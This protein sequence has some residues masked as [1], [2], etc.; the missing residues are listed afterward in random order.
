M[1]HP[2]RPEPLFALLTLLSLAA[3]A[4]GQTAVP[5]LPSAA[6]PGRE[7]PRPL[8]PT[9]GLGAAPVA[10]PAAP[11]TSAPAGA[12]ALR[13][14]LARVQVDGATHFGADALKPLYADL[15]GREITVAQAFGVAQAL[16]LRY[17]NAGFVTTRVLVP[18]QTIED[19]SFRI[20][21]V[22]GFL[23]DIVFDADIGPARAAVE[24]LV[25]PLKGVKPVNLADIERRLLL[26]ND[27]GG[28]SVRATLEPAP[29]ALGG[30][31]LRVAAQRRASEGSVSAD[32]RTSPYLGW[33][34]VGASLS[35]NALGER[36]DRIGL[37][38]RSSLATG[39]SAMA[40]VAYDA[41]LS[42]DGLGLNLSASLATS[43]PQRELQGLD[44]KS[45]VQSG[46]ATLSWPLVRS[47]TMN[48]RAFGQLELRDVDTD[49]AGLPFT[50]DRLRVLRAGLSADRADEG[51][52]LSAGRLVLHQGLDAL[53]ARD[54]GD[55]LASRAN[56]RS[57][58]TKLTLDLTRLQP[59][60][61]RSSL[62]LT[63]TGQWSPGALLASEEFGLGGASFGRAYDDG[64][65]AADNGIAA[66]L[67]L[68]H[69]PGWTWA[70]AD[71]QVYAFADGGR[72][73]ADPQGA[74]LLQAR[75]L[76]S[77]GGGVRANVSATAF[78]ALEL[79]KPT[80]GVPRTQGDKHPRLFLKWVQQF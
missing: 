37:N 46:L 12:D 50:R 31:L 33:A 42:G 41:L 18:Q 52:G 55:P 64:E 40:A 56:G 75:T 5:Q 60:G 14:V 49:I 30:S 25:A 27:L 47:R 58:F 57:N 74:P 8:L 16:E 67:E 19:G 35:F 45:R 23:S 79:A 32:T 62:A 72:L 11:S 36:A 7:A 70:P 4:Q 76:S 39:R 44:V 21:V 28:L 15:L 13:F 66:S 63:L 68:R 77:V 34:S 20:Q 6:E 53:G 73:R 10:V 59:L 61:E 51:G 3:A 69:N 1:P 71:T 29:G 17:R 2:R 80:S 26:A 9:P 48:L 54:R 22:E 38:L 24:R 43:N 78:A 65:I